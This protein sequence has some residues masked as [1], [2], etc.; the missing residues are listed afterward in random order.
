MEKF[1][2]NFYSTFRGNL[3]SH[4]RS[5][6]YL[7]HLLLLSLL[8]QYLLRS[9]VCRSDFHADSFFPQFLYFS[10]RAARRRKLPSE[11][12][13]FQNTSET[14]RQPCLGFFSPVSLLLALVYSTFLSVL[15][16]FTQCRFLLSHSLRSAFFVLSSTGALCFTRRNSSLASEGRSR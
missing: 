5:S 12:S 10:S 6:S 3:V 9:S 16:S 2:K 13:D 11:E 14:T 15:R 1:R 8:D 4:L 7:P